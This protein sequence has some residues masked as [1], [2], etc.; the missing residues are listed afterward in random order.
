MAGW[1]PLKIKQ[2]DTKKF[3]LRNTDNQFDLT[4]WSSNMHLRYTYGGNLV[5]GLSEGNGLTTSSDGVLVNM[6]NSMTSMLSGGGVYDLEVVNGEETH[7]LLEGIWEVEP[8][9]TTS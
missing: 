7:T 1:Y 2:G 9:V 4:G 3:M 5:L 8:E 6:T